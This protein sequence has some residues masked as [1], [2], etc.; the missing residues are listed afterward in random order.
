MEYREHRP[1]PARFVAGV[2][3]K[4][5]D[6]FNIDPTIL[7]VGWIIFGLMNFL[8]AVGIY[9]AAAVIFSEGNAL[10]GSKRQVGFLLVTVGAALLAWNLGAKTWWE[11][12]QSLNLWKIG[13]WPLVLV[14]I[15]IV[16]VVGRG[17]KKD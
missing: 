2:C 15:G 11:W 12:A 17:S 10:V 13:F 16:L 1:E 14:G 7:R 9:V 4:L 3:A 6:K 5:G 8:A